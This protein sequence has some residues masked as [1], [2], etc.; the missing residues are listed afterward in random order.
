M[1]KHQLH[2][3][4]VFSKYILR[5]IVKSCRWTSRRRFSA[6][7]EVV[8]SQA[9]RLKMEIRRLSQVPVSGIARTKTSGV[10][11]EMQPFSERF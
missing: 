8:I 3:V 1:L 7:V 2:A 5:F 11:S 6:F 9:F 4:R 10:L